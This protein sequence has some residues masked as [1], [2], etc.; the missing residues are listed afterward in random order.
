[1]IILDEFGLI[2]SWRTIGYSGVLLKEDATL[3]F[4]VLMAGYVVLMDV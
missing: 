1:M 2:D 4:H 3:L